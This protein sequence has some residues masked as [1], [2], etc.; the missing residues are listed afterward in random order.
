MTSVTPAPFVNISP[1]QTQTT[2]SATTTKTAVSQGCPSGQSGP[3]SWKCI[4]AGKRMLPPERLNI[5][6]MMR[7]IATAPVKKGRKVQL[8]CGVPPRKKAGRCQRPQMR[9]S[10]RPAQTG[11]IRRCRSGSARPRQPNSSTGPRT[12]MKAIAGSAA[13]MPPS[14]MT[15]AVDP[16]FRAAPAM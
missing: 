7:L 11:A 3:L 1:R 13:A 12:S 16:P 15:S 5:G 10:T 8:L 2:T 14:G 9:P 6:A 4:S